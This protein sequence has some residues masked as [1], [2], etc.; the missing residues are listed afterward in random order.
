MSCCTL[1][2]LCCQGKEAKHAHDLQDDFAEIS[3]HSLKITIWLKQLAACWKYFT[4]MDE[5]N[6]ILFK[7]FN[8]FFVRCGR[9]T[10]Y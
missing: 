1:M 10:L 2:V 6:K 8:T 3:I 5:T 7:I 4:N 9:H